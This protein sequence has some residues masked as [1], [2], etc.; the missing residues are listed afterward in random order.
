MRHAGPRWNRAVAY[1][2]RRPSVPT[3]S[4]V[5]QS[6]TSPIWSA[7]FGSV[8]WPVSTPRLT[9]RGSPYSYALHTATTTPELIRPRPTITDTS[10]FEDE[11]TRAV[12]LKGGSNYRPRV[13][14]QGKD[15]YYPQARNL[16]LHN[17]YFLFSDSFERAGTLGF[18]CVRDSQA[19]SASNGV[20]RDGD[21]SVIRAVI[22]TNRET[23]G[24]GAPH[25]STCGFI[26]ASATS[27]HV[28]DVNHYPGQVSRPMIFAPVGLQTH[29]CVPVLLAYSGARALRLLAVEGRGTSAAAAPILARDCSQLLHA[30]RRDGVERRVPRSRP[31]V[32]RC[33]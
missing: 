5:D 4:A 8:R 18:R 29:V 30:D 14:Q 22:R 13:A 10:A 9:D 16:S 33:P 2:A 3:P 27:P 1:R 31:A 23:Q 17:K 20:A 21:R 7:T 28:R 12:L 19:V 15:W 26:K 24:L 6:S 25:N 11:R 32:G